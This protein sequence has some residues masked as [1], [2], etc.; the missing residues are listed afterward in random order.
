MLLDLSMTKSTFAA[1]NVASTDFTPHWS[2]PAKVS[3][4]STLVPSGAAPAKGTPPPP[5]PRS[6]TAVPPVPLLA[7][8][9]TAEDSAPLH[10]PNRTPHKSAENPSPHAR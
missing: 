8:G 6:R 9:V 7:A 3:H 5:K 10:A 2:S 4:S 1:L